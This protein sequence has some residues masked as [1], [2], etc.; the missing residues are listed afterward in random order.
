MFRQ[1]E[2]YQGSKKQSGKLGV[3]CLPMDRLAGCASSVY[4]RFAQTQLFE[5]REGRIRQG[6]PLSWVVVW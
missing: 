5:P 1:L 4:Q 3:V 2:V 6:Q